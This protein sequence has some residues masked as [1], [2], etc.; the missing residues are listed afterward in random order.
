M[1][2]FEAAGVGCFVLATRTEALQEFFVEG[3]H[4]AYF[5]TPD[6]LRHKV[7]YYLARPDERARIASNA[8]RLAESHTYRDRA[9]QLLSLLERSS[10]GQSAKFASASA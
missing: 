2:A 8:A 10:A 6:E 1:R 5:E 3:E 4:V 9:V 7:A